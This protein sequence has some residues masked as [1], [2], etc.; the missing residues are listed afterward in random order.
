MLLLL[1]EVL[2]ASELGADMSPSNTLSFW[3]RA[4]KYIGREYP[5]ASHGVRL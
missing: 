1:Q 3:F 4:V 5:S 2:C